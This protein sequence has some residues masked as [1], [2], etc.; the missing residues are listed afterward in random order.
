MKP[1]KHNIGAQLK[2][3]V[4]RVVAIKGRKTYIVR[5]EDS[6]CRVQ[7]F[8]W[9]EDQPTPKNISCRLVSVNEFGF[10]SFEQVAQQEEVKLIEPIKPKVEK[11]NKE[12]EKPHKNQV[13]S[14]NEKYASL[15][16]RKSSDSSNTS[17]TVVENITN[18]RWANQEDDFEK[19]FISTG[20][21][22][23][24]LIILISLA[25]QLAD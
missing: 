5:Y 17:K 23:K 16:K 3:P 24:R 22:K 8:D 25:E 7:M 2:L 19:W 9:Q 18:Y 15:L 20:G 1:I 6:L 12:D 4:E 13:Q 11:E 10:P 14:F 21:I